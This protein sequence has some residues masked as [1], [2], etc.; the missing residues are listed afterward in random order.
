MVSNIA[1]QPRLVDRLIGVGLAVTA[2]WLYF[3]TLA[4]TVLEADGGEFQFVPWLPG[5]AH[6]TGYPLYI[7]LGWLW[8]HLLPVGEVAWRMNLLSAVLAA[9]SVGLAYAV[10]RQ[11]V[12]QALPNTPFPA[13]VIAG[14]LSAATFAAGHTFWSQAVI[15]EVYALH[16]LFVA[17]I[18]WLALSY[19]LASRRLEEKLPKTFRVWGDVR[20]KLLAFMVGLSLTHH[21]TIVLL[22]P[23]LVLFLL[24]GERSAIPNLPRS[25]GG[26]SRSPSGGRDW[27]AYAA[28][29][30]TPLLLY[31]Y[32]P[33][34][35]PITPYATLRLSETQT[36]TLYDNSWRGFW[37]HVM[38]SVF[39]AELQPS[40]AGSE[41]LRLAWQLLR[42]QVGLVGV[43][44]ALAGLIALW[45]RRQW[46]ILMLTGVGFLGFLLFNL[47]YFIED[48]FVLFIPNWLFVSLWLGPGNLGLAHWLAQRFV[49]GKTGS[50]NSS[51]GLEALERRLGQR[52]YS[53]ITVVLATLGLLLP[54]LLAISYYGEINQANNVAAREHWQT[55]LAEPIPEGAIL[56]SNDRNEIMPM[57]Y[58]QYV[59]GRRPDLLGLFPLIVADPAY[60]NVGR[61]LDQALVSGRPVYLIK[62]MAGLEIKADLWPE[63]N[64][65][66]AEPNQTPATH[67][68]NVSLPA[69]TLPDNNITETIRLAGYDL[70]TA[71]V[72]AGNPITITL[73]WQAIQPLDRDYTSYAH[74]V[75][76]AGQGLTQSDQRP[77]GDFYPS[78]YWQPGEI[79]RDRHVFIVPATA[80]PGQYGLRVGLYYQPEPG[81][82]EGMGQGLDIGSLT[83]K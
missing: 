70:A 76:S 74:L 63:G 48:V 31:L 35:A 21:R 27:L 78:R 83:I 73:H 38:G 46:A 5:I 40:A 57:W 24:A 64:L 1:S 25:E 42:Q 7:L 60:T 50:V 72:T 47:V 16:T 81:V 53:F 11:I 44:L 41:R 6:P 49:Q 58:Y 12:D 82:I 69:I 29:L 65:V 30:V 18:L 59:E 36:L 23:A 13:R 39:S 52:I 77:G 62:S 80:P 68:L 75:N 4:P 79:V 28:F 19:V 17:A 33:L 54:L 15:A 9:I 8:T 45:Q 32:L 22:L 61:V 14:A 37:E 56:L 66:R 43:G 51:P 55:I 34:I 71:T 67:L 3:S 2:F 26:V 10:A 20:G